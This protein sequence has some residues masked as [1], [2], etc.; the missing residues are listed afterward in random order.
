[1]MPEFDK[2]DQDAKQAAASKR[3][4]TEEGYLVT[5]VAY[6][7]ESWTVVMA[8]SDH[9]ALDESGSARLNTESFERARQLVL[10]EPCWP[11]LTPIEPLLR[12]GYRISSLACGP[13]IP[14]L[15]AQTTGAAAERR[16]A[17]TT[18]LPESTY[19]CVL[20]R[21]PNGMLPKC[22]R[23]KGSYWPR[24]PNLLGPRCWH[25]DWTKHELCTAH[26]TSTAYK[27]FE[28]RSCARC[29]EAGGVREGPSIVPR[30]AF[31]LDGDEARA[32]PLPYCGQPDGSASRFL[33]ESD[34][35]P[36]PRRATGV[37]C[38]MCQMSS[39]Q[40]S[41]STSATCD[42]SR[43]SYFNGVESRMSLRCRRV[44][45]FASPPAPAR[46]ETTP[47]SSWATS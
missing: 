18:P 42:L 8:L 38:L 23:G 3:Q 20:S 28:E 32:H 36:T 45:S 29:L 46:S 26:A 34:P 24:M 21:C 27:E 39:H 25:T 13:R 44:P 16:I 43:R 9:G 37:L 17:G 7:A 5:S 47:Q 6:C 19:V 10:F 14:D 11:P 33:T 22:H 15:T 4:K 1:M 2:R 31:V 35:E 12:Y 41:P 30:A 40:S